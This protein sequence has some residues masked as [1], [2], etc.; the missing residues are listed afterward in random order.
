MP[1]TIE[2]EC[3]YCDPGVPATWHVHGYVEFGWDGG[4]AYTPV[5]DEHK[6]EFEAWNGITHL[7]DYAYLTGIHPINEPCPPTYV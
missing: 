4:Y 1:S 3:A 6:R 7:Y 2:S 5:C